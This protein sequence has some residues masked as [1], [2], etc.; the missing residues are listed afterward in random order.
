M[1]FISSCPTQNWPR[2]RLT[3][4]VEAQLDTKHPGTSWLARYRIVQ[5]D[6]DRTLLTQEELETLTWHFNFTP[7]AGGRGRQTLKSVRFT[8]RKIYV[9][10]YPPLDYFLV[11]PVPAQSVDE[12]IAE[13]SA[14]GEADPN[15]PQRLGHL[16]QLL[17]ALMANPQHRASLPGQEQCVQIA[18]FPPH[19]VQ[20]LQNTREWLIYNGNVTIVSCG[21]DG[22][23]EYDER[24]FLTDLSMEE[25]EEE[26]AT[27]S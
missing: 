21:P 16:R 25:R 23:G 15:S 11:D 18:N 3:A 6:A 5:A 27:L 4:E 7:G 2:Y 19:R 14:S 13:F 20:R 17:S 22:L 1:P 12:A 10:G 24:G 8:E 9:P 26:P